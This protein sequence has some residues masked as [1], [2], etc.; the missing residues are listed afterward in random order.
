MFAY[1]RYCHR[2]VKDTA[3]LEAQIDNM[4]TDN[5]LSKSETKLSPKSPFYPLGEKL[6]TISDKAEQAVEKQ[7]QSEKMKVELV[8]NV[9]HDLKTPLTSII[10]YIDLLE[11]TELSDEAMD[12]VKILSRKSDKLREIVADVFTL[13]K[14]VSGVEVESEELDFAILVRQVL[15]DNGDKTA[16][17]GKDMRIDIAVEEAPII[18]DG[19]KLYRVIQNLLDNALKYSMDGTR[20]Y[21]KLSE[22]G[23]GYEL[24]VKNVSA[25]EMNFT[26]EEITERFARGDKSR[27]DGGSGLGLSIA[28][29]F[30]QACGG[31]FEIT[32]DGDIFIAAVRFERRENDTE[33]STA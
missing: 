22:S 28:K 32:I 12:Y 4:L 23:G 16:L 26:A 30:T 21:L 24:T 2:F 25:Y 1:I 18:G 31:Q 10:S 17:S 8:T 11:K 19:A 6:A 9:S 29:S 5:E 3:K 27:T 15:A 14:A 20:I 33:N 7:V 13:A